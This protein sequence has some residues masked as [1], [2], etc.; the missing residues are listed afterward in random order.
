LS[1]RKTVRSI[2]NKDYRIA[3]AIYLQINQQRSDEPLHEHQTGE[4][5]A[6]MSIHWLVGE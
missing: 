3:G 6:D 4:E 2:T 1:K 5:G